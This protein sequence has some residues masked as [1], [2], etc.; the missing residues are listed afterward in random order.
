LKTQGVIYRGETQVLDAT[1]RSTAPGKF[2]EL[3]DAMV[4]YEFDGPP[5]VTDSYPCSGV[6]SSLFN[7]GSHFCRTC[8]IRILGPT[9]RPFWAGILGQTGYQL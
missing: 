1:T 4:H 5:R 7:L 9:I 2:V 3:S 8:I 6:L